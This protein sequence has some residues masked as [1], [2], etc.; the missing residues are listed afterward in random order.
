MSN[1]PDRSTENPRERSLSLSSSR[2][3]EGNSPDNGRDA[4][5]SRSEP[6][7]DDGTNNQNDGT[8]MLPIYELLIC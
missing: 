2:S 6:T 3:S 1:S 7:Y 8:N 4:S 5:N